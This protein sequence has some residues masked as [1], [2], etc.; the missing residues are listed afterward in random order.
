VREVDGAP[1][2]IDFLLVAGSKTL[3]PLATMMQEDFARA[4][5]RLRVA[6]TEWATLLDRL[7]KH[8]FDAAALQ[9]NMRPVQDN[10]T[11]FHSSQ[12]EGGQNYGAFR[13][14]AADAL[15]DE[16]KRTAPGEARVALDHRLHRLIAEEQPYLFL[17]NPEVVSLVAPSVGGYAPS[18]DGL[19]FARITVGAR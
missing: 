7:R 6:P 3:E 17:G 4:G 12:A 1:F 15:L 18:V 19:G 8:A 10:W 5:I 11:L 13:D 2:T 14:P 16:I 9:W